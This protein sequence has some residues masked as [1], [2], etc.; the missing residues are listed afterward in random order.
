MHSPVLT[1]YMVN[2][3]NKQN[4]HTL[5]V[6]NLRQSYRLFVNYIDRKIIHHYQ[7][8]KLYGNSYVLDMESTLL[9][10]MQFT[11]SK[12]FGQY[13]HYFTNGKIHIKANYHESLL[14]GKVKVY[15]NNEYYE[16]PFVKG[17][18]NG[19]FKY[20]ENNKLIYMNLIKCKQLFNLTNNSEIDHLK[21]KKYYT[22]LNWFIQYIKGKLLVVL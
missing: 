15:Y 11:A 22:K 10:R 13:M 9:Y 2:K 7:N 20:M 5:T 6:C 14:N 4:V 19:Y 16:M 8:N 1:Q 3:Y 21:E 12:L 18:I 17:I